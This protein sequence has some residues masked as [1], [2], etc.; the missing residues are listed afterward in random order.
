VNPLIGAAEWAD[1]L[2]NIL[3]KVIDHPLLVVTSMEADRTEL[4]YL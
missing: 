4:A 2:L 3:H 1:I